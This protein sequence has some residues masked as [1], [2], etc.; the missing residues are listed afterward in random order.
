MVLVSFGPSQDSRRLKGVLISQEGQQGKSDRESTSLLEY[1]TSDD[2]DQE[3]MHMVE[4]KRKRM[5]SVDKEGD[6]GNVDEQRLDIQYTSL[7]EKGNLSISR[8]EDSSS[9]VTE[10]N[11][12]DDE[13]GSKNVHL[14]GAGIQAHRLS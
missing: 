6:H 11:L 12:G 10:C 4:S 5:S 14:V 9:A 8:C 2:M 13:Q 7:L 3:P 1:T